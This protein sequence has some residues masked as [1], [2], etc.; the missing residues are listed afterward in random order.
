MSFSFNVTG[1]EPCGDYKFSVK[2]ISAPQAL[3]SPQVSVVASA[4]FQSEILQY[5]VCDGHCNVLFVVF[6]SL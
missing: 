3:E 4:G 1:L 5:L 2:A 6:S